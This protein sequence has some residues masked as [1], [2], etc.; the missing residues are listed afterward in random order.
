MKVQGA[1]V[2]RKLRKLS[3]VHGA[4]DIPLLGE[5]IFQ[6]LRRT[7][8]RFG[9]REALVVAH[10]GHRSTYTELVAQC[11]VVARGLMTR[12]VRDLLAAYPVEMINWHD[13]VTAPTLRGARPGFSGSL[14]GG[15]NENGVLITG[16][17]DSIGAEVR[18]AVA[19]VDGRGLVIGPGCVVPIAAAESHLRAVL[20]AVR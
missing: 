15:L 18:D 4:S 5:T 17:P 8:A 2:A 1:E 19:Q 12:G 6:N 10:Q 11:E 7:A 13:R 14:V 9:Q 16:T 20:E 3:Y